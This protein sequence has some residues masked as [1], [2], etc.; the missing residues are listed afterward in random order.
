MVLEL[1]RTFSNQL[2]FKGGYIYITKLDKVKVV[3][4]GITK[5]FIYNGIIDSY[6]IAGEVLSTKS[7]GIKFYKDGKLF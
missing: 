5:D 3:L 6:V 7:G 2:A 1:V 4:Y